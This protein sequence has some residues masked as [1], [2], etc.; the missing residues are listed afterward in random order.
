[1]NGTGG[2]LRFS[3]AVKTRRSLMSVENH[4]HHGPETLS[5][6]IYTETGVN[7]AKCYQCGKCSAG[8]PLAEDMD[9]PPSV[10]M[11]LLQTGLPENE[12]K[13]LKSYSI[14]L[15]LACET[16]YARCPM[17]IDIPKVADYLRH[18]SLSRK[19]ANPKSKDIISFHRAFLDSIKYTG[20]LYEM[21]L[22]ADYKARTRHLIQDVNL[23]PGMYFKGKLHIIPER[24]IKLDLMKKIFSK[25]LGSK[26][27]AR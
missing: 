10:I 5:D 4:S 15:C 13:A 25:T 20:R 26:E 17:E 8:C 3:L 18:E 21:G 9:F 22:I 7:A 2:K 6:K 12:E 23:A 14:W 27:K 1:M 24:I 16:C 11:R 19:I